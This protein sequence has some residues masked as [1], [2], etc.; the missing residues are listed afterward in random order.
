LADENT[1]YAAPTE[2]DRIDQAEID[3]ILEGEPKRDFIALAISG[4][5]IRSASFGLGVLQALVAGN[6]LPKVD[7]LSTVSGGG[8]IGSCLTWFLH[9]KLPDGVTD[10]GTKPENFP[11]GQRSNQTADNRVL[12]F[13]RQ[14][15]NYM[16]PGKGLNWTSLVAVLLRSVTVSLFVYGGLL[17]AALAGLQWLGLF[18]IDGATQKDGTTDILLLAQRFLEQ[19]PALL[20]VFGNPLL[21]LAAG[22]IT[23]FAVLA[24]LYGVFGSSRGF[25]SVVSSLFRLDK[26]G[27]RYLWRTRSQRAF[28]KLLGFTAALTVVGALPLI[29]RAAADL[30]S[31]SASTATVLGAL[32][33]VS[34]AR[35]EQH[36]DY[37][38]G[39]TSTLRIYGGSLLL[40]FGLLLGAYGLASQLP[41]WAA[42][43][44]GTL[45]LFI[46]LYTNVNYLSLHRMYRD[47]LMETFLPN[48]KS[49]RQGMWG[50]ATEADDTPLESFCQTPNRR[51]YHVVNTNVVLVDSGQAKYR[52]RGGDSFIFS[53]LFCGSEA[54]GWRSSATYMKG[55]SRAMN[56]PTAMAIS[57]A[58]ANPNTGVAGTGVTRSASVSILMSLLNLRLGYWAPNPNID[59]QRTAPNFIHPGLPALMGKGLDEDGWMLELTDGGH[60]E[61]LALY[62]MIRRRIKTIIVSDAGCDPKFEFADLANAVERVRVDFGVKISFDNAKTDLRGLLPR[63]P[64]EHR[65]APIGKKFPLAARG[66]AVGKIAYPADAA[67]GLEA[68]DGILLYLKTTLIPGLPPDLY[69]Y[70]ASHE[71]FPDETTADQFF[72]EVQLEAYRELGYHIG[73]N[74]LEKSE[75]G[76]ALRA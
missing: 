40:I 74:L 53:P 28:G 71:T 18:G 44:L 62:E 73:W 33:A 5:G 57:G 56:L 20:A 68:S 17:L 49:V 41:T 32:L 70:K 8:Y 16:V 7:Y 25:T 45:A 22:L 4:G 1:D 67:R 66:F 10:A 76:E 13:L 55:S 47:R 52:G 48:P 72:S 27:Q 63:A 6:V 23:T 11:L 54:T 51:P 36:E 31:Q 21:Q 15:G 43:G 35:A 60:F 61:N 3:H 59:K 34:Q 39:L 58:A 26:V 30:A 42:L 38:S 64:E 75:E 9:Q 19:P 12:N 50:R 14:H 46:G 29:Y 37:E 69:G 65:D 24:L 2:F